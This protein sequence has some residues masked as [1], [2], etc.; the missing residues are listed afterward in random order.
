MTVPAQHGPPVGRREERRAAVWIG[1]TLLGWLV[2]LIPLVFIGLI[3]LYGQEGEHADPLLWLLFEALWLTA[4]TVAVI[5]AIRAAR[6][7]NRPG[8]IA[9]GVAGVLLLATMAWFVMAAI[10]GYAENRITVLAGLAAVAAAVGLFGWFPRSNPLPAGWE[11]GLNSPGTYW[12][13]LTT[14]H[15][16]FPAVTIGNT[17]TS[18]QPDGFHLQI[19][20]AGSFRRTAVT[21]PKPCTAAEVTATV[22][23]VSSPAGAGFGPWCFDDLNNGY[24][25]AL[26]SDGQV[27]ITHLEDG[28]P[29]VIGG[30]HAAA[31]LPGQ[32]KDLAI[33]CQLGDTGE[34]VSAFVDGVKVADTASQSPM[35]AIKATG[36][37]ATVPRAAP[38]PGEWAV[39]AFSRDAPGGG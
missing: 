10:N 1:L 35:P 21:T 24:G 31:W 19:T 17:T 39:I 29:A 11:Y 38:G 22:T 32:T 4:P 6:A 37:A 16:D 3:E 33:A 2:G 13:D 36:F 7:G 34:R 18:Y 20:Q 12:A 14:G 30:G 27:T 8:R 9:L 28:T 25:M 26:A 15:G 23:E 5:W